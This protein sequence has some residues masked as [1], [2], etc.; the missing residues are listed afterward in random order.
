MAQQNK[1]YGAITALTHQ[2]DISRQFVYNLLYTLQLALILSFSIS[3]ESA[4]KSKRK[5]V[6]KILSLR[7]EG[8]SPLGGMSEVMK[9]FDMPNCSESYISQVL[10]E[11]G[12]LLPEAQEIDI[13]GEYS[14]HSV[15]DEIFVKSKPILM[16]AEPKSTLLFGIS[17]AEDRTADTWSEHFESILKANPTLEITGAT[18]DQGKGLCSSIQKTFPF[19]TRQ[20][21]TYHGVAHIFGLLRSRFEK[22]VAMAIA[23]E[24]ERDR[25]CM[26]RKTDERF[27]KKYELYES[28]LQETIQAVEEYEDFTYLYMCIIKQLQPFYSDGE[29]RDRE[30]AEEEIKTALDLIEE[31]GKESINKDVQTVRGLLPELLNYFEQTKESV[32]KCQE[33]GIED[34]TLKVLYLAWQWNKSFIKA[35]KKPRRDRAKWERDFYLEYA[36]DLLGDD[37][38]RIKEFVFD[39]LNN[40]IQASSAIENLNSILRFYLDASRNQTTQEFLNIFMFYH[41]HRRYKEGERKGKTPMEI[42]TGQKQEKDWIELLLDIVEK[43]KPDF[44]L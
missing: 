15:A 22:K 27:E 39:E 8:K 30:R 4:A 34:S 28:A 26:G 44:F 1:S 40:I 37:F 12:G 43:K 3:E 11:I 20:P 6:E 18:T 25:V 29:T 23:K 36:E 19:I 33:T 9:R 7:F 14:A 42:F 32:K 17:L 31:L 13:D 24:K 2:Y 35:R 5:E 41:N 16:T 38:E 21:D 10:K